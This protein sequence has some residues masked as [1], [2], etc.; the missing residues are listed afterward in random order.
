M[1]PC[2]GAGG[3]FMTSAFERMREQRSR[4]VRARDLQRLRQAA[5]RHPMDR[6]ARPP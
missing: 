6:V 5:R 4:A 1:T 3:S 2:D